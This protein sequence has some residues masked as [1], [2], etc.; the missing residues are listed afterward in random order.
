MAS[1]QAAESGA[2]TMDG[3][4]LDFSKMLNG[5]QY[6]TD[7]KIQKLQDSDYSDVTESTVTDKLH[8]FIDLR[9]IPAD[10]IKDIIK[11]MSRFQRVSTS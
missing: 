11:Y 3:T 10:R 5:S 1:V 4:D 9:D 2:D 7:F 6:V 8:G